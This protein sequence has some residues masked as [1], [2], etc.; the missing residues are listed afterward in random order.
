MMIEQV[1]YCNWCVDPKNPSI[2]NHPNGQIEHIE[3]PSKV[4]TYSF[5][6]KYGGIEE[7]FIFTTYNEMIR[8]YIV[9][10]N[11]DEE[12][13]NKLLSLLNDNE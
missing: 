11:I 8:T 2:K 1:T 6:L 10:S 3:K 13:K 9:L 4:G 12:A 5:T 7:S